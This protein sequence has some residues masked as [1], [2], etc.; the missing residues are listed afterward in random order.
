MK[1]GDE[2]RRRWIWIVG[3][4]VMLVGCGEAGAPPT[5]VVT[6]IPT[7]PPIGVNFVTKAPP[8][9]SVR[10]LTPSPPPPPTVTPSPTPIIYNVGEGDT[11]GG[12]A[13]QRGYTV[14]EILALNPGVQ[15]EL[16][17]IGQSLIL[18]PPGTPRPGAVA[19]AVPASLTVR[20][21]QAYRTPADQVW[22][23]GVVQN[24]GEAAAERVQVT[25]S[26]PAGGGTG[27]ESAVAWA[28][29]PV[30]PPGAEA[31]FA[32]LFPAPAGGVR[33]PE[34]VVSGGVTVTD[35]GNRYLELAVG[36]TAVS[37][38][39]VTT[40]VT[41]V[42]ANTGTAV[43]ERVLLVATLYDGD[44]RISGYRQEWLA[45]P[46]PPGES[47]PFSLRATA[48]GGPVADAVVTAQALA[49]NSE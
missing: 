12:I 46:L 7:A 15:P 9:V 26:L 29:L 23:L 21:V 43:A 30:L 5:P 45:D 4:L 19:T 27:A 42:V 2:Q 22:L 49:T 33:T 11:L 18:P 3:W 6:H 16:L 17:Q 28:A 36:E 37:S 48:P 32:A 1:E 24:T 14:D 47:A 40:Q 13:W 35:L 39:G 44:G 20:Q 25:V 8:T 41:G 10:Q 38:Q 34:V 31:P